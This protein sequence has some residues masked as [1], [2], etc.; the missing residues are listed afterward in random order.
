MLGVCL[1]YDTFV[2]DNERAVVPLNIMLCSHSKV[3]VLLCQHKLQEV[4]DLQHHQGPAPLHDGAAASSM[5][6]LPLSSSQAP[7]GSTA[8]LSGGAMIDFQ[9]QT[10]ARSLYSDRPPSSHKASLAIAMEASNGN[11]S[12]GA[13][14]TRQP[15]E[16]RKRMGSAYS[17]SGREE[18]VQ[19]TNAEGGSEVGNLTVI[20]CCYLVDA[21][22]LHSDTQL[23]T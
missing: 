1:K 15:T 19:V 22:C 2:K 9:Q 6:Q 4:R 10:T 17:G 7:R 11:S 12:E 21:S 16:D 18:Y 8:I 3:S 23:G 20:F 14:S 5:T 13:A